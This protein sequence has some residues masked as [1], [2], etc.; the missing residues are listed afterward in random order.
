MTVTAGIDRT[1]YPLGSNAASQTKARCVVCGATFDV[2]AERAA[3]AAFRSICRP[4]CV[5]ALNEHHIAQRISSTN[6]DTDVC[7][8]GWFTSGDDAARQRRHRAHRQ[9][10]AGAVAA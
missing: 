8:C 3:T 2:G 6:T 4:E 10:V 9:R 1:R 7:G 5:A